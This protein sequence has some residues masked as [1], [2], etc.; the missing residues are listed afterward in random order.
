METALHHSTGEVPTTDA[1]GDVAG[2]FDVLR[3]E[4]E[5][6][7]AALRR[8]STLIEPGAG[9][10]ASLAATHV[11][12]TQRFFDAQRGLLRQ[13]GEVDSRIATLRSTTE[14]DARELLAAAHEE[15]A[16]RTVRRALAAA[17]TGPGEHPVLVEWAQDDAASG[18][19]LDID[20]LAQSI[21]TDVRG[22]D[23]ISE[24]ALQQLGELLDLWWITEQREG[25]DRL[26]DA[27]ARA[28]LVQHL[29]LQEV[30]AIVSSAATDDT[31]PEPVADRL[32]P[33]LPAALMHTLNDAGDRGLS[34]LLDDLVAWLEHDERPTGPT[35]VGSAGD[36]STDG[37]PTDAGLV[38]T[39]LISFD[40]PPP[41]APAQAAQVHPLL[42]PQMPRAMAAPTE[43]GV[44]VEMV[45]VRDQEDASFWADDEERSVQG[46]DVAALSALPG[47]M[48]R[49]VI[50]VGVFTALLGLL[51]A[52][53]G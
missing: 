11:R 7:L 10:L 35:D 49:A 5:R 32:A 36:G 9:Q 17:H 19:A 18:C 42:P 28:A 3:D 34:G 52:W 41:S 25:R 39:A 20:A 24:M 29:V 43:H 50:P 53:I 45:A 26:D 6:L 12:L 15:A 37:R 16:A 47:M 31:M 27:T 40:F 51:M 22:C 48:L 38:S 44:D 33:S 14:A 4:H 1:D 2:Y 13:R 8:A 30:E 46:H 21:E 23:E